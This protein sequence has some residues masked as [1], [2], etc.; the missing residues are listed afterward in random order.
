MTTEF[1]D[2]QIQFIDTQ[3]FHSDYDKY[4]QFCEKNPWIFTIPISVLQV[5]ADAIYKKNKKILKKS[6]DLATAK[7]DVNSEYG[8]LT[9]NP[10]PEGLS[11]P[12]FVSSMKDLSA[13]ECFQTFEFCFEQRS[14]D[15]SNFYGFHVHALFKRI[16]AQSKCKQRIIRK[17][18]KYVGNKLHIH[19]VWIPDS[20]V[21]VKRNYMSGH[22]KDTEKDPLKTAKSEVDKIFRKENNLESLYAHPGLLVGV[23]PIRLK[24]KK[25]LIV[26][27]A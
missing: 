14:T 18:E 4:L 9:I 13:F 19:L 3:D 16:D 24:L 10:N 20:Q 17:M 23:P 12:D 22:K 15:A 21:A 27:G 26:M 1:D 7:L 2:S 11:I 6:V 5:Q 8:W 25:K